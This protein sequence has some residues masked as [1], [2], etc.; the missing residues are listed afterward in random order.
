MKNAYSYAECESDLPSDPISEDGDE[1]RL[2]ALGA[3]EVIAEMVRGLGYRV[4]G[5]VDAGHRGWDLDVYVGQKRIWVEVQGDS[6]EFW[7]QTEAMVGLIGRLFRADLSHYR[8]FMRQLSKGLREDPRFTS[9]RWFAG[10]VGHPV[11]E[12]LDTPPAAR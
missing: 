7:L 9:V 4:E 11:G 5:P 3:A 1:D 10:E 2:G 12:P 8:D 6:P